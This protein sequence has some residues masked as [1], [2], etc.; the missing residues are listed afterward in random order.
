VKLAKPYFA[1]AASL[2]VSIFL[3]VIGTSVP[4]V[5]ADDGP[6][7]ASQLA[8]SDLSKYQISLAD[9]IVVG[10]FV[11]LLPVT[12]NLPDSF[13]VTRYVLRTL[14]SEWLRGN[15][16]T[17]TVDILLHSSVRID[18]QLTAVRRLP[19]GNQLLFCISSRP[20]PDGLSP[21]EHIVGWLANDAMRPS[22]TGL[23]VPTPDSMAGGEGRYHLSDLSAFVS[24]PTPDSLLNASD[25]I[26]V[27][28][29]IDSLVA[30]STAGRSTLCQGVEVDSV[31]YGE[32]LASHILVTGYS[33]INWVREPMVLY[34]RREAEH[35]YT[36][37]MFATGIVPIRD[38]VADKLGMQ[39]ED[40]VSL[41]RNEAMRRRLK[42]TER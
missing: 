40:L 12:L 26:L 2:T 9:R 1:L 17:D 23:I 15:G 18:S 19:F 33:Y 16:P 32:E 25:V 38:G 27:G 20:L 13:T 35:V 5:G 31:L 6:N 39:L 3:N 29:A 30:C 7:W 34:L 22:A 24:A 42:G 41:I 21:R 11:G 4:L 10:T 37:V 14:P 28:T 36:P 8:D